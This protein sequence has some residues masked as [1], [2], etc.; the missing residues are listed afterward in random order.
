MWR[1]SSHSSMSKIKSCQTL[2]DMYY[3]WV[4]YKIT[5]AGRVVC[6][7]QNV[8]ISTIA[9][10]RSLSIDAVL[11]A[12]IHAQL[13]FV[14]VCQKT[15][16]FKKACMTCSILLTSAVCTVKTS[17]AHTQIRTSCVLTDFIVCLRAIMRSIAGTF[18]NIYRTRKLI[19]N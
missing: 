18:I 14:Y 8:S 6:K 12:K 19:S 7:I 11:R 10:M 4:C 17:L 1:S 2:H 5:L 3:V 13:T 16:D 15:T 9:F